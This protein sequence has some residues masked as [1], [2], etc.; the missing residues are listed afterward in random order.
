MSLRIPRLILSRC[1]SFASL[2]RSETTGKS[3]IGY[4]TD[5]FFTWS[6]H[7]HQIANFKTFQFRTIAERGFLELAELHHFAERAACPAITYIALKQSQIPSSCMAPS[8][9]VDMSASDTNDGVSFDHF[10]HISQHTAKR[11]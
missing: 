5:S 1:G 9:V 6:N 7:D 8:L 10:L 2:C 3:S 4:R 11:V